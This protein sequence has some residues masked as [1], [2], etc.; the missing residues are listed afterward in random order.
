MTT[1]RDGLGVP[2]T[3]AEIDQMEED[4]VWL[5]VTG[6]TMGLDEGEVEREYFSHQRMQDHLKVSGTPK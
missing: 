6:Y 3:D 2:L 1:F 5:E 4:E